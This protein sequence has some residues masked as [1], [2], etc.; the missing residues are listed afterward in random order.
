M[1]PVA[2]LLKILLTVWEYYRSIAITALCTSGFSIYLCS[3]L[4]SRSFKVLS[5]CVDC[6]YWTAVC[7]YEETFS[8]H[9]KGCLDWISERIASW[10]G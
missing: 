4:G 2:P 5:E 7:T 1:S 10:N 8:S 3:C 6:G 9:A